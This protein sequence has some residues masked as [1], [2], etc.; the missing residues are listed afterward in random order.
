MT[1]YFRNSYSCTV[2]SIVSIN[3]RKAKYI[4]F[5]TCVETL[6]EL[7]RWL[8]KV[9]FDFQRPRLDSGPS[10][11]EDRTQRR[12]EIKHK[13]FKRY[14]HGIKHVGRWA[15]DTL[16]PSVRQWS[17]I[18]FWEITTQYANMK[19]A[20]VRNLIFWTEDKTRKNATEITDGGGSVSTS[21][22]DS[23]NL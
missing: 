3:A 13:R 18:L 17:I 2:F 23:R 9:G 20:P 10:W 6:I 1:I 15:I 11:A 4:K 16:D 22:A 12:K 19:V 21:K 14:Q 7:I 8:T 5:M